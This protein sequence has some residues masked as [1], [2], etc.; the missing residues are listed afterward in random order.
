MP[1]LEKTPKQFIELGE[2]DLVPRK[3]HQPFIIESFL[4]EEKL[5]SHSLIFSFIPLYLYNM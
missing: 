4:I 2:V 1:L 3:S 5:N